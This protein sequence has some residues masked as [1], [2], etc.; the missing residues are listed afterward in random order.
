MG[1]PRRPGPVRALLALAA[2]L[3]VAF[4]SFASAPSVAAMTPRDVRLE[5][6]LQ[7]GMRFSSTGAVLS[8][9]SVTYTSKATVR[10]DRRRVVPNRTGIFLRITTG[11]LAGY[12]VRTAIDGVQAL[13]MV[14]VHRPDAMLTDLAMPSLDGWELLRL[15]RSEPPLA[16]LPIIVTSSVDGLAPLAAAR[17][18]DGYLVKPFT[19]QDARHAIEQVIARRTCDV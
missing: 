12:E 5:A 14:S 11:A 18:A 15:C 8:R 7:T 2:V 17:G 10:A 9:R 1:E 4:S 13:T 16:D 6:G 3:L 19:W